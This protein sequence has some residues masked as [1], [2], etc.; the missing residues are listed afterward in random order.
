MSIS[1]NTSENYGQNAWEFGIGIIGNSKGTFG[2]ALPLWHWYSWNSPVSGNLYERTV[3][4]S[5]AARSILPDAG[6][7]TCVST[8]SVAYSAV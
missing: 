2:Q 6:S 4:L 8:E 5:E 7:T 3:P 1:K